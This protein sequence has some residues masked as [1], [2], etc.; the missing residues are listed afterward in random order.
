MCHLSTG[1]YSVIAATGGCIPSDHMQVR[2]N[3]CGSTMKSWLQEAVVCTSSRSTMR[4]SQNIITLGQKRSLT[5]IVWLWDQLRSWCHSSPSLSM[6]RFNRLHRREL[7]IAAARREKGNCTRYK[8]NAFMVTPPA[9]PLLYWC[10]IIPVD[11]EQQPR[12]I[13]TL[14]QEDHEMRRTREWSTFFDDFCRR[15]L[16]HFTNVAK[17][18]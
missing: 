18:E 3:L 14:S 4:R 11:G 10:S 13:W 1:T 17:L 15:F 16:S 8:M 2:G 12:T 6:D 7:G 9:W 5:I